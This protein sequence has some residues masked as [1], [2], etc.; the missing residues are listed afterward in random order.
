[1]ENEEKNTQQ[2][3]ISDENKYE[4][5]LY[6]FQNRR[7]PTHR[8]FGGLLIILAGVALLLSRIPATKDF[9]PP[10]LFSWQVLLIVI[11]IFI[12]ARRGFSAGFSWLIL[13]LIGLYSLLNDQLVL[14]AQLKVYLLPLLIILLGLYLL[15]F[16]RN[17]AHHYRKMERFHNRI[18]RKRER[19]Q[20]YAHASQ[21]IPESPND[22]NSEDFVNINSVMGSVKKNVFTKSFKGGKISCTL[23]VAALILT[24]ADIEDTAVLYLSISFGGAEITIPANWKVQNELTAFMGGVDDKRHN[25]MPS[26]N[27]TLVLKGDVFCGGVEIRN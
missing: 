24:Q 14:G 6:D 2:E 15:F 16:R 8:R 9:F 25:A 11:G 7:N 22:N 18:Q 1:M 10:W 20:Q 26:Q 27:K 3:N 17:N 19:W 12:G 5:P 21:N 4:Q 13:I 23:G